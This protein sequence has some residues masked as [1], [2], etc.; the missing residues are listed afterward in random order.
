LSLL[1]TPSALEILCTTRRRLSFL[2]SFLTTRAARTTIYESRRLTT[3]TRY[4]VSASLLFL[5]QPFS[6]ITTLWGSLGRVG[7]TSP[8]PGVCNSPTPLPPSNEV[9]DRDT[10]QQ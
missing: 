10:I 1:T 8:S 4:N 7:R 3:A 5:E 2:P 6:S 9:P